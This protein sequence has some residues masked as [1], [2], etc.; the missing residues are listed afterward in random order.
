MGARLEQHG[1]CPRLLGAL[2][3]SEPGAFFGLPSE[4]CRMLETAR[5]CVP[6]HI[7][8]FCFLTLPALGLEPRGERVPVDSRNV[9]SG[10]SRTDRPD[11]TCLEVFAGAL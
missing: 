8:M 7:K 5:S 2:G 3:T 11:R 4:S 10:E 6:F 1:H 9:V